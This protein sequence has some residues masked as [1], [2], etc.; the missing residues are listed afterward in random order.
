M[1]N[2][3]ESQ[4]TQIIT[5]LING[6]RITPLDA[7]DW[8]GCFRLSARISELKKEGW[9]IEKETVLLSSGKRIAR[10]YLDENKLNHGNS[11]L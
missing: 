9:N 2:A 8:F 11:L 1:K 7:L 4:N 10:Y 3:T 5:A 6:K